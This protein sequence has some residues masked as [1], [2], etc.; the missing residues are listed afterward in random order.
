MITL[1]FL[2]TWAKA[3]LVFALLIVI[4]YGVTSHARIWFILALIPTAAGFLAFTA[5]MYKDWKASRV[6]GIGYRY[7]IVRDVTRTRDRW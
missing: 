7:D 5:L 6:N 4:E 1:Y 2:R 3:L